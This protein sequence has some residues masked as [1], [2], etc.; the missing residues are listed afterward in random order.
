MQRESLLPKVTLLLGLGLA[1]VI[2]IALPA[3]LGPKSVSSEHPLNCDIRSQYGVSLHSV[4]QGVSEFK[5]KPAAWRRMLNRTR[6]SVHAAACPSTTLSGL[7][8][9]QTVSAGSCDSPCTGHYNTPQAVN[10]PHCGTI[11]VCGG[12]AEYQFGCQGQE[13]GCANGGFLCGQTSC[14]N[15]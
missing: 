15:D 1:I 4:F 2:G 3:Q 13:W 5:I 14:D 6:N 9:A 8:T 7:L 12:G 10:V 11:Y